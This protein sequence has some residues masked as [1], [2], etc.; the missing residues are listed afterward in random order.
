[1]NRIR[2]AVI[3]AGPSGIAAAKN[4]LAA[5]FDTTVFEL[6][7][8]VGG[9]WVFDARTGH[10]SVYENTHIISSKAWSE[11]EDFPMPADYPDYPSHRQIQA[12]FHAYAEHFQVLPRI[13]FQH[14]V[15]H[16][17]PHPDG[18]WRLR[19]SDSQDAVSEHQFTHLIVCNGHHWDPRMPEYPGEFNGRMMHSHDFKRVDESWRDQ[20]VLVIGGGN[21][22][23]DVAVEVS[24]VSDHIGLS[25]RNPQ[26]FIPKF[27]F[28]R[29]T[30]TLAT[31]FDWIPRRWRQW[32][33][34]KLLVTVQGKNS[35]Y[36]LENP[37]WTPF[38]AHPTLNQDLLPLIRHGRIQPRPGIRELAGDE[39][40]FSDGRREAYDIIVAATGFWIRF[41]FFDP[42]LIDYSTTAQ[43][44]LYH[45]MIPA[46]FDN[47]Y[48]IGLFQPLGC[49]WPL[50]DYQAM[51]ACQEI[52]GNWRRPA[53]MQAAI[54]NQLAN[55]HYRWRAGARHSAQVD[56]HQF[57]RQLVNDLKRSGITIGPPPEGRPGHYR[58]TGNTDAVALP[59]P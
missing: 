35:D 9:N 29:P 41:P 36:G 21:S 42:E 11:Y 20:R 30:D 3:G 44:P 13:R 4:C 53:D 2:V 52:L 38:E 39:V 7:D 32:F 45:K 50:A 56:Y 17:E 26:W 24:R 18:G 55:P 19:V 6:N 46:E 10:S 14:R 15:E 54:A 51:L 12:Y 5:G 33:L 43:V 28:G 49:I 57:R 58:Q 31:G 34:Q 16:A 1:M 40:V 22:A 37:Q 48:F 25:M 8:R 47:L 59:Q 27:M 23:C